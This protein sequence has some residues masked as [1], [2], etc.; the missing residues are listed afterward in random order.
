MQF[1]PFPLLSN[2]HLQSIVA[3]KVHLSLEPPSI[4]E[5][6]P[7][8]DG[9]I[10]ALEISTPQSWRATDPTV[11]LVH[12]LCGCHRSPY[13]MRLARKLRKRGIRAIRMNQRGCGSGRGLARKPY[14]SGRS[15]D[16]RTVL[17]HLH[18]ASPASP[19]SVMGFS[20]GGNIVLKLAGELASTAAKHLAQVIAV[21]PPLDLRACV[22]LLS[23]PKNRLYETHFVRLL[24]DAVR[25]RHQ[26]FPD[27]PRI[28]LPNPLS[29]YD[30]DH[31]YTA[32]VCGFRDADDYY[33]RSGAAPLVPNIAVPCRILFA[34]DDP[35]IDWTVLH[36]INVPA[37]VEVTYTEKGGHLGF[38]GMPGWP[39]GYRWMDSLLLDWLT[40]I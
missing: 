19:I 38:L 34:K 5:R 15:E 7:L 1:H 4:T 35:F 33:A 12:G 29:L 13:M 40:S 24:L 17:D 25:D 10:V 21:C 23:Q 14:H 27:L 3:A 28:D 30:F 18:L 32:P 2:R 16:V 31:L 22:R 6:V 26:C 37:N 36:E 20:M 39:G 8:P 11:V 9:D